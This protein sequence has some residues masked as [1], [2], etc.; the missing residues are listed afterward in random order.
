MFY[1]LRLTMNR[2]KEL[3]YSHMIRYLIIVQVKTSKRPDKTTPKRKD[4]PKPKQT[5]IFF[6]LF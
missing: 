2:N 3:Q 5:G 4:S 6:C 1:S